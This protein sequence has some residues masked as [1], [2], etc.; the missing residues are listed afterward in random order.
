MTFLYIS[1][2]DCITLPLKS[3][4]TKI[5]IPKNTFWGGGGGGSAVMNMCKTAPW[6][7]GISVLASPFTNVSW[8]IWIVGKGRAR[9]DA[10]S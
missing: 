7:P 6:P 5:D 1:V 9:M 10:M 3:F 2:I 8:T 4:P